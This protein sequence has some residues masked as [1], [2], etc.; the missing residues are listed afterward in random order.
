MKIPPNF[1]QNPR[2]AEKNRDK[3][4]IIINT[5]QQTD[6]Q[7][8]QTTDEKQHKN[9]TKQPHRKINHTSQDYIKS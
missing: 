2:I 5:K 8:Y 4:K 9:K 6:T 1:I 7:K 3:I